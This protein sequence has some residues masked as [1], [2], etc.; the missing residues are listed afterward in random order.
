[1]LP[2]RPVK[3]VSP[4]PLHAPRSKLQ[5]FKTL[6]WINTQVD[7]RA[8]HQTRIQNTHPWERI[9]SRTSSRMPTPRSSTEEPAILLVPQGSSLTS[10][11]IQMRR[12]LAICKDHHS[13]RRTNHHPGGGQNTNATYQQQMMS[14]SAYAAAAAKM[15]QQALIQKINRHSDRWIMLRIKS[16]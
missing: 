9:S 8:H 10:S 12:R 5:T 15:Q 7:L 13:R 16:D 6:E 4:R 11:S 3:R 14:Q 2:T 1:M